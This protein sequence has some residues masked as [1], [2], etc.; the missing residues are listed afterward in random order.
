MNIEQVTTKSEFEAIR[1]LSYEQVCDFVMK[2][3]KLSVEESL[4]VLP[5]VINHITNQAA[6][7]S[8]LSDEFYKKHPNLANNKKM[9]AQMLEKA[10]SDNPSQAYGKLLENIAPQAKL[11]LKELSNIGTMKGSRELDDLDD[12]LGKL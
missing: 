3:V 1:N 9:V 5:A 6:Y 12:S 11:K 10:E 7:V 2:I 4:K 8:Q